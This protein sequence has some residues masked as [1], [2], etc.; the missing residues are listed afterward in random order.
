VRIFI[1]KWANIKHFGRQEPA[2]T[3]EAMDE[4]APADLSSLCSSTGGMVASSAVQTSPPFRLAP[5]DSSTSEN[6]LASCQENHSKINNTTDGDKDDKDSAR[7]MAAVKAFVTKAFGR[8]LTFGLACRLPHRG[9]CEIEFCTPPRLEAG[10]QEEENSLSMV[11]FKGTVS[12]RKI[13]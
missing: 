6:G 11:S 13:S 3:T 1:A 8:R 12:L 5:V 2:A 4:E 7:R 9:S 10:A